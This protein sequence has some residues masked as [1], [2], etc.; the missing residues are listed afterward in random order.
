VSLS[1]EYAGCP[2]RALNHA[3]RSRAPIT[4]INVRSLSRATP[5]PAPFAAPLAP[6][7]ASYPVGHD[8]T[9]VPGRRTAGP[10]RADTRAAGG[11]PLPLKSEFGTAADPEQFGWLLAYSPYHNV[12]PRSSG[13][14]Y[15]ATLFTVFEGDTRVEPLHAHKLAAALQHATAGDRPVLLRSEPGVGHGQ[16]AVSRGVGVSA[17]RLAFLAARLGLDPR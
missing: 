10:D 9:R 17:D 14:D 13:T 8:A 1:L 7:T 6:P 11:R 5:P 12:R 3:R 15:P 16:R 2:S 4:A